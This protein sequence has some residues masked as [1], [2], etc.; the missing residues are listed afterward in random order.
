[1]TQPGFQDVITQ[2][3]GDQ[4]PRVW[5]LL[6]TVFGELAQEDGAQI[7]G[8]LLSRLTALMGIKPEAMRVALHRLRKDG[9]IDSQRSGRTSAYGLT[10]LGRA[11]SAE[12]TPRIYDLAPL[13]K[14][15][16]L[17]A[18]D[19]GQ[20]ARKPLAAE[21]WVTSNLQ[22]AAQAPPDPASLALEI[23]ASQPIPDWCANKICPPSVVALT[24]AFHGRLGAVQAALPRCAPLD[25]F[26]AA[27]L[28]ILVVDGWRRIVLRTPHLPDHVFPAGW[29]GRP[30]KQRVAELLGQYGPRG[31]GQL[32]AA[33]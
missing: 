1:M 3:K 31:L 29:L 23:L 2:L 19:P 18:R 33:L 20:P 7:S 22:V 12:A 11:Q 14:R 25:C 16:W 15:A 30:C 4:T 5:S 32:E 24:A 8:A 6:V 9:W 13:P 21:V 17:V 10:D 27:V 28:R 26:E